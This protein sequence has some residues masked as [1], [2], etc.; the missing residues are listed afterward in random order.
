MLCGIQCRCIEMPLKMNGTETYFACNNTCCG[1]V[2]GSACITTKQ[3]CD[4][5]DRVENSYQYCQVFFLLVRPFG[6]SFYDTR[7]RNSREVVNK[8]GRHRRFGEPRKKSAKPEHSAKPH[9]VQ[10]MS[11]FLTKGTTFEIE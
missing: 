6:R 7:T 1:P 4:C 2:H 11:F 9:K 5:M 8:T 10:F 3:Y